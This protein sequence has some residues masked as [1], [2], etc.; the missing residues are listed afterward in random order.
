MAKLADKRLV[1]KLQGEVEKLQKQRKKNLQ[2]IS[3]KSGPLGLKS[4]A[5]NSL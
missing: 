4:V 3:E 2:Q 1:K 5:Q